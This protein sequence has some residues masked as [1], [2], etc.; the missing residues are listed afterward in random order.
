MSEM[1]IASSAAP[2]V[3]GLGE[4]GLSCVRHFV[5]RGIPVSVVD[6]R[7]DPPGLSALKAFAPAVP[8]ELG[9]LDAE[10]LASAGRLVV[11]P[12][13][14]LTE[15][16]VAAAMAAGVPVCGDI[17]IFCETVSAPVVGITGSNGK[18]TVTAL[19][20]QMLVDAGRRVAVGG[21]LGTPALSLLDDAVELYVLELSSFQLERA[22]QLGLALAT[23]LNMSPD[24]M[25]R[26]GNMQAYHTAKHRI[27]LDCE[28]VVF[29]RDD[30]LSRP[31][32]SYS[33]PHWSFGL[34]TPDRNGYGLREHQ[35]VPWI[36]RE[37][38]PLMPA[39]DVAM[40]GGHNLA[41]ALAGLALGE[42]LAIPQDSMLAT[43]RTFTGLPHR[44]QPVGEWQGV[45]FI[46]DSKA[47]NPGATLAALE[48]LGGDTQ[49]VIIL[50]GQGKGADFS[51]LCRAVAQSCRAAV[52]VGE[53]ARQFDASLPPAL[54]RVFAGSME[55]AVAA[56]ADLAQPGDTVLLSP[57]CA[58]FDM[59]RGFEDRGA[60]F[61]ESVARLGEAG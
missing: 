52:L 1:L 35:G 51:D 43:L 41:N 12:G 28:A 9:A 34:G 40:L 19:L 59:F 23:V 22:G 49:L 20:G 17:D 44:C 33:V 6:S 14:P 30:P 11:S 4:T 42:L 5:E 31:L 13:I 48:G 26:H 54:T 7:E 61:A 24:H 53:A 60:R 56:A 46:N 58:S 8:V 36:F 37:F 16:A 2:T 45:R 38:A 39:A 57:A 27:F 15:P 47:T 50:G 10:A 25:D 32:Q 3:V 21:N 18:S 55:E 29:N